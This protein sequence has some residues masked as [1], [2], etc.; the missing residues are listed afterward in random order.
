[1]TR[2]VY[3]LAWHLQSGVWAKQEAESL[4]LRYA[5]LET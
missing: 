2:A 4:T 3:G 1:M 5:Q